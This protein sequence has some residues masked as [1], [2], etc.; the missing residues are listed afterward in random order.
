M[1]VK[2]RRY[3]EKNWPYWLKAKIN[4]LF[5]FSNNWLNSVEISS[6]ILD[7]FIQ[8]LNRS[9]ES[10]YYL[11]E[12]ESQKIQRSNLVVMH[13][14]PTSIPNC[15]FNYRDREA[16]TFAIVSDRQYMKQNKLTRQKHPNKICLMLLCANTYFIFHGHTVTYK[17]DRIIWLIII[18]K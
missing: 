7:K 5:I 8:S 18:H 2:F 9:N 17:N 1:H 10:W 11:K 16:T 13:Y 12:S 15:W 4:I 14:K 6:D 3:W